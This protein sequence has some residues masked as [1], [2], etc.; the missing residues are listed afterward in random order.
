[1]FGKLM[2]ELH[3][4]VF[5]DAMLL[6]RPSIVPL[7]SAS[8][9]GIVAD[10]EYLSSPKE[11]ATEQQRNHQVVVLFC[12]KKVHARTVESIL[13]HWTYHNC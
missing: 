7:L 4:P 5:A 11:G 1:M 12:L 10:V 13:H 3:G 6:S 8:L 2:F 9:E